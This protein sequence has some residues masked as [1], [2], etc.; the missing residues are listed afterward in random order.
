MKSAVLI[1]R[2]CVLVVVLLA[3]A[4]AA[5]FLRQVARP[6]APE[7][8]AGP[9]SSSVEGVHESLIYG[10]VTT[11]DGVIYEGRIRF[12]GGEEA[13]WGDYFNGAKMENP[14]AAE[15]PPL[16]HCQRNATRLS[17]SDS[18]FSSGRNRS[19]SPGRSWFVSAILRVLK[20]RAATSM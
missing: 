13:F 9:A 17:Y 15:V 19:T 8:A 12:G 16:V 1:G 4:T 5:W 18:R 2:V 20:H 11:I 7:L 3:I 10:R 14:W 6:F